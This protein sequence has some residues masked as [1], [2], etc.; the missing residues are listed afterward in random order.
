[1]RQ[2]ARMRELRL[3]EDF[4][5]NELDKERLTE[6]TSRIGSPILTKRV[7]RMLKTYGI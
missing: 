1:M 3:D 2:I 7:Q 6:Y 4:I 5:Q